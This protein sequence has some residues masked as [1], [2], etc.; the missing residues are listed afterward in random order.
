MAN[1]SYLLAAQYYALSI[2]VVVRCSDRATRG[3]AV[4]ATGKILLFAR[5]DFT[6]TD[7]KVSNTCP[8]TK[9]LD[10]DPGKSDK[11]RIFRAS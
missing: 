2:V 4:E 7:P 5:S 11:G 8:L 6:R 10:A 1:A 9:L 3:M